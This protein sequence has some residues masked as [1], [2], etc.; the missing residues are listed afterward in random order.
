MRLWVEF[1]RCLHA[2]IIKHAGTCAQ[3]KYDVASSRNVQIHS[4]RGAPQ[5]FLGAQE[6]EVGNYDRWSSASMLFRKRK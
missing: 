1:S 2:H 4:Y 5:E 6:V 3:G